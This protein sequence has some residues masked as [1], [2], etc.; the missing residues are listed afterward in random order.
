MISVI[1][2]SNAG[3]SGDLKKLNDAISYSFS[4]NNQPNHK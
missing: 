4:N 1:P 2:E 3:V